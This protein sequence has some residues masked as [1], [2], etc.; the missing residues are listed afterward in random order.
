MLPVNK[1][2]KKL[3]EGR[4]VTG[5]C[6]Y[7]WSP[8]AME[9]AGF[10]GLDFMRIDNEHAWRQDGMAEHLVRA[11]EVSGI[12]PLFRVDRDNPYLVRK[13]LEIGAGGIIVPDVCSPK[14]AQAVVEAAKFPPVGKRGYS[15]N[16]RSAHWG[17]E[18]GKSWAEWSDS[19]PLIGIMI[20]NHRAMEVLE[21][22]VSTKGVDFFLF[23]PADFSMSL[24]L[25]GPQ[26]DHPEVAGALQKTI[27]VA[28]KYGKHVM[29]AVK[30]EAE[31]IAKRLSMGL[32]MFEFTNDLSILAKVWGEGRKSLE[33]IL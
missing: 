10:A 21:D 14:D 25:G 8:N 23:G 6:L 2:R 27:D 13:A 31:I 30:P 15:G 17:L 7:S 33:K 22:I 4:P 20:E 5:S 16:C 26:P 29:L 19:E 18:A 9:I 24:G 28:A 12:T 32:R 1:L 3:K 11:A